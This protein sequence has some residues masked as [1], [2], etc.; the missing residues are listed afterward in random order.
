MLTRRCCR[1]DT[2]R[3]SKQLSMLPC[4]SLPYAPSPHVNSRLPAWH[5]GERDTSEYDATNNCSIITAS[6]AH[7]LASQ[8]K[9]QKTRMFANPPQSERHAG[10]H[11]TMY[12]RITNYCSSWT[13]FL[14]AVGV[15]VGN[16]GTTTTIAVLQQLAVLCLL[17]TSPSPRD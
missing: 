16:L 17:Y 12:R 2:T 10:V 8:R 11:R 1:E 9:L 6:D 13:H 14:G 3:G 4:P 15:F 5:P 7:V